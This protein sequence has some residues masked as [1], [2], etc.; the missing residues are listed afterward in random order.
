[1]A[2]HHP[3]TAPHPDDVERLNAATGGEGGISA[4][5][6]GELYRAGLRSRAY[7]AVYNGNELAS[8]SVR[9]HDPEMQRRI[10]RA[11]GLG[12]EEAREKFGFLLE[13]FRFGAPPHA[14]FAFGFDRIAMLLAGA[15]SLRDVIAFPKT[16]AARALFEGAPARVE[17]EELRELHIQTIDVETNA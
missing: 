3:F 4:E 1:V 16:T 6:A 13:A 10:F 5:T 11:L 14:G 8:G 7:D 9:I 17:G 15:L 2:A 12:A